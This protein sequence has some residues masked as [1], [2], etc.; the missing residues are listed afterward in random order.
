MKCKNCQKEFHYCTSCDHDP[1]RSEGYC[2]DSC[3]ETDKEYADIKKRALEFYES[4]MNDSQKQF[5]KDICEG[6]IGED[7]QY[8]ILDWIE[9]YEKELGKVV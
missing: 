2:S 6:E 4:L 8:L 1:C 3:W 9:K 5:F 7:Y